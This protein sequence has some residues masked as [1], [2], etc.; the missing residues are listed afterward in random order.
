MCVCVC[1]CV[2]VH[3]HM[4]VCHLSAFTDPTFTPSSHPT[5]LPPTHS[6]S[7]PPSLRPTL[8][9]SLPP[10]LPGSLWLVRPPIRPSAVR[11]AGRRLRGDWF[12]ISRF[13]TLTSPLET[14]MCTLLLQIVYSLTPNFPVY[15]P[16]T[17]SKTRNSSLHKIQS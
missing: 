1:V 16:I 6:P 17:G 10:S 11:Q 5:L 14:S 8:P 3:A 7:L 9:P 4:Y 2:C 12:M 15:I 13:R